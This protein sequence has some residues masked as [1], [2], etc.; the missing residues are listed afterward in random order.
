MKP[1]H[2][3]MLVLKSGIAWSAE[4][5]CGTFVPT[6]SMQCHGNCESKDVLCDELGGERCLCGICRP[7]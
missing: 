7:C 3:V 4:L 1:A 6:V 2:N 5:V